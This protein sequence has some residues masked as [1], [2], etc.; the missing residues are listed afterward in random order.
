M[1]RAFTDSQRSAIRER[2]ILAGRGAVNRLGLRLVVDEVARDAGISKGS[3][4]SFFPTKEDFVLSVLESWED[5]LRG[6]LLRD[7]VEGQGTAHERWEAFFR[8]TFALLEREPGLARMAGADVQRLIEALPAERLAAHQRADRE[9]LDAAVGR[10]VARGDLAA[11]D[12]PTLEGVL[13]SL[14]AMSLFRQNYPPLAWETT[15][16]FVSQALAARYSH[17]H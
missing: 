1:P 10:L 4:Y 7:L 2:L 5:E 16:A 15:V 17:G 3:F 8:G 6:G 14:F 12:A 9:V 11:G 13:A